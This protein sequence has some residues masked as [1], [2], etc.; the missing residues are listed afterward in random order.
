VAQTANLEHVDAGCDGVTHV[1][2]VRAAKL[3]TVMTVNAGLGGT[4]ASLVFKRV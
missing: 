1:R 4:N 3:R 2:E